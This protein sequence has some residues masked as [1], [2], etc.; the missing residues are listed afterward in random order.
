MRVVGPGNGEKV[1]PEISEDSILS[2]GTRDKFTFLGGYLQTQNRR[3][4]TVAFEGPQL[5]VM[6]RQMFSRKKEKR[7]CIPIG[8]L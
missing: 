1:S 8:R 6:A 3:L 5:Q 7:K 2:M 4:R